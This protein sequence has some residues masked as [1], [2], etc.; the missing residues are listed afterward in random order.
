MLKRLETD[1]GGGLRPVVVDS[2]LE[3]PPQHPALVVQVLDAELV[4]AELLA[5]RMCHGPPRSTVEHGTT[6]TS[7]ARSL[8]LSGERIRTGRRF[9]ISAQ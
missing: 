7:E 6:I 3:L 1:G 5:S 2:Q 4:A 9:S 8:R